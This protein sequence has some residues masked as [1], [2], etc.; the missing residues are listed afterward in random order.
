MRTP[1]PRSRPTLLRTAVVLC[2]AAVTAGGLHATGLTADRGRAGAPVASSG[3]VSPGGGSDRPFLVSGAVEDLYPGRTTSLSLRVTNPN[4]QD[5]V[6]TSLTVRV[7]PGSDRPG[8]DGA[9]VDGAGNAVNLVVS[10][11][12]GRVLVPGNGDA[13]VAVPISMPADAH[14]ACRGATFGLVYG[15]TGSKA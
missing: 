3:R 8:C 9:A 1:R 12:R 4:K 7:K 14:D 11:Y 10:D 13:T 2:A 6:V 5:I 15:G